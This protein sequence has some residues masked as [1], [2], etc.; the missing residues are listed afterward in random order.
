MMNNC[1]YEDVFMINHVQVKLLVINHLS[2]DELKDYY[3]FDAKEIKN[4]SS[5]RPSGAQ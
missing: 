4:G 3:H 5:Q 1:F 2:I